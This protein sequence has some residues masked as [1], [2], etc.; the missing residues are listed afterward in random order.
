MKQGYGTVYLVGAGPGDPGLITVRGRECLERADVV[1]YDSL[2]NEALLD[3]AFHAEKIYA[4]K[5]PDR[6]TLLQDEINKI[7]IDQAARVDRVVRL[8]GGDPFVFGR[9]AEE[10]LA[11]VAHGVPF[12]VVPGITSGIAV[13]AYA[14]IPVTHRGLASS[15]TFVAGHDEES[16]EC[17]EDGS[18]RWA[19]DGTLVFYMGVRRLPHIADRLIT[20]GRS[21]DTPAAVVQWGTYPRQISVT[22]TL[23]TIA[24]LAQEQSIDPPSILVVGEVVKLHDSI[25]WYEHRPLFG[26]RI[27]VTRA[28]GQ[29]GELSKSLRELGADVFEFP[30]IAIEPAD[31][32]ES[33]AHA[34]DFDWIVLTSVN[35]AEMLF[36]RMEEQGLD[37]RSLASVKLCVIGSA[38]AEAVRKRFLKVDLMPD[39][40]VAED[41]MAALTAHEG[42][43]RGKRFLLPRADIARSFLPKE[44]RARGAEVIELVAYRTVIPATSEE[45]AERLMA[46]NPDLVTFT[47]SSTARNFH[48][49]IGQERTRHLAATARFAGIGPI[50]S[51]TANELGLPIT[52]EPVQHDIPS[53]VEAIVT[54]LKG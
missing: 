42:D 25:S 4:G 35:G 45:L 31:S 16:C 9:G 15:V 38:T 49:M 21:P 53:F 14:G 47:S 43:L 28:R 23:S 5:S 19:L 2:A 50:T 1:V 22:G 36:E 3:I 51:Q 12:E 39:K 30:T 13:P 37:G 11:L 29:A 26:K 52:I 33:Y 18:A 8:K 40:Y 17:L 27:V 54:A 32:D 20:M 48:E 46:Y 6:H 34:G 7:L 44:L 24:A 41:L 10:A